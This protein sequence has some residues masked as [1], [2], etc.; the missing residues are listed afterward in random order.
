MDVLFDRIILYESGWYERMKRG[1]V[2]VFVVSL[3]AYQI[4][5]TDC[6]FIAYVDSHRNSVGRRFGAIRAT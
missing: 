2:V 5:R 4:D 1:V 3:V 6:I